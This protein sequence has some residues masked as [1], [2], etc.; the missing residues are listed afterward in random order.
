MTLLVVGSVAFDSVRGPRG[1]VER[2]LGGSATYFSIAASYFTQ[3]RVVGVVGEDFEEE[4]HSV[5]LERGVC[6]EGLERVPGKTFFWSGEYSADMNERQ[7]LETQLNV[8]ATFQPKLPPH[9]RQSPY[10]FLGNIDPELQLSV[11]SQME[12]PALVAGDTMNFWIEGK[13]GELQKTLRKIHILII[14]DSEARQLSGEYNLLKAARAIQAMG[15]ETVVIKRGD[16]GATMMLQ[17]GEVFSIPA[18]PLH[19]VY[20]PTGAGDSFAANA[21]LDNVL[22]AYGVSCDKRA[23]LYAAGHDLKDPLL[24]PVYG[25]MH[26]FPPAILTTGTR[27][28]LLSNTVRVHR[29]L[30]QAGVEAVLQVFE[31]QAHA[32]YLRDVNAPETKDAFAEIALFFDKHLGK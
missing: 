22:V 20:D 26:G 24:S 13:R 25:D 32:Q 9:Y 2:M 14:N 15:P 11:A 18:L 8:F 17:E 7:T 3:V 19:E 1:S 27:D 16:S 30:R 5:L 6:T 12:S 28:L 10:L 4:H 23:A 31:G 29:K 21:M